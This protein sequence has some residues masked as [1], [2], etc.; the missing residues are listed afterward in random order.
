M[1]NNALMLAPPPQIRCRQI[2]VTDT[3]RIVDLLTGAFGRRFTNGF[4]GR[5]R[6][7]FVRALDRLS[8]HPTPP[9]FP[10]YGYVLES[11]G[12]L[13]GTLLLIYSSVIV[14]G[15]PKVRCNVCYWYVDPAFRSHASMLVSLALKHKQVTYTNLSP[16]PHTLPILEKQGYKRYCSGR[17][18]SIPALRA[19][20]HDAHV[21]EVGSDISPGYDL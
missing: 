2:A 3:G 4:R 14:D 19:L 11:E 20:S 5:S 10:K 15:E 21:E 16:A 1:G 6:D 9:G 18:F 13:V 7:F 8:K 12:A 17:F